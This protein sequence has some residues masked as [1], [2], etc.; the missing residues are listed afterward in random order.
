MSEKHVALL[1]HVVAIADLAIEPP[2]NVNV[3]ERTLGELRRELEEARAVP[4]ED[5]DSRIIGDEA[6]MLAQAI[7]NMV[8]H[9]LDGRSDR[10]LRW[11]YLAR[12]FLAF[13]RTDLA[14]HHVAEAR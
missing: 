11:S 12:S 8:L 3:T 2:P 1:E 14:K 4:C 9:R 6:V 7:E 10:A 13:V 5:S